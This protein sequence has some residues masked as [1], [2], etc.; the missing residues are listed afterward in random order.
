[1]ARQLPHKTGGDTARIDGSS[2]NPVREKSPNLSVP[3]RIV[4]PQS[5]RGDERSVSEIVGELARMRE[6]F[7]KPT[8]RLLDR[9]WAPLVL[10]VF[11]SSFGRDQRSVPAERLHT[12]VETYLDELR[13]NGETVPSRNGRALC[14][15][16]MGD[17]WLYRTVA[18][19]GQEEYSP[20]SHAL[21]ALDLVHR[22]SRERALISE[23]RIT[24]ILDAVRKWAT[25]ANPDRQA[26]IERLELQ[27]RQL[28]SEHAHLLAGGEVMAA[29]D[30][31]M[32]DGYAN[33][34]DL[35]GALPSDFKRVEES[36]LAM[37][38]RIIDEFR[39]E[40]RL[41]GEVLD[42]Y[43]HKSD[44]LTTLTP[45]GRAFEGAVALLRDDA[46]L[47]DLRADLDSILDHPFAHALT[48]VEQRE[49]RG[50]VLVIRQGI[51]DVLAQRSRLTSTLREHIVNHDVLRDR[52]LDALLRRINQQ[53]STWMQTAGPR[54]TVPLP[55]IPAA[56]PVPHLRERF[57]DPAT[58]A[59]PPPLADVSNQAPAPPDR[60]EIRTQG[61]PSFT[62]LQEHLRTAGDP[63]SDTP[64]VA[65][66]FN[67]LPAELRRPVEILGLLHL[68]DGPFDEELTVSEPAASE[69]ARPATPSR[70]VAA[71]S[72]DVEVYEAIRPDG[73]RQLFRGR[74]REIR[75]SPSTS[76]PDD[77]G[78]S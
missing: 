7:D 27:I 39:N 21:E 69:S 14:V 16:W 46:L 9:K 76:A 66:L 77:P 34:V 3:T 50:T 64:T 33:L 23:S 40:D 70:P 5:V 4:A 24:T 62:Q 38:R 65:A 51:N 25:E 74:R 8:L 2:V 41:I 31:R 6:A 78:A 30:D 18:A 56:V 20:T 32:V 10:A 47:L 59:P 22:L 36:V 72:D 28:E 49:F 45:E 17:Q 19:N 57:W 43:L 71:H 35:I 29:S 63:D 54:A 37:H 11:K 44:E 42:E 52:E 15:Q 73:S 61:G 58:A 26:R 75:S 48:T 68:L 12:Q 13:A 60:S 1:M 53:L 55:L 67:T